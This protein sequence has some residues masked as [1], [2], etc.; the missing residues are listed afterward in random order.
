M[1]VNNNNNIEYI[2]ICLCL[3]KTEILLYKNL[4]RPQLFIFEL[5]KQKKYSS[6]KLVFFLT[7]PNNAHLKFL[8][9][10]RLF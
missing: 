6:Q 8:L 2:K 10:F 5:Q 4:K 1:N 7:F 9:V 3:E